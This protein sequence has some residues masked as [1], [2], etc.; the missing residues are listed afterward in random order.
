MDI[1]FGKVTIQ[2][3]MAGK[4]KELL[5]IIFF[6]GEELFIQRSEALQEEWIKD[7]HHHWQ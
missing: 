5:F 2:S 1:S 4:G 6:L 7:L 3:T